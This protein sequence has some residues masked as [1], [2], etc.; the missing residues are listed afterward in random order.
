M[1]KIRPLV[2][3][4]A[5]CLV[6]FY[7]EPPYFRLLTLS[8]KKTNCYTLPTTPENVTALPCKMYNF[9]YLA[10]GMLYFS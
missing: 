4:I 10:E 3:D 6:G 5:Y 7:F 1:F 2:A 8:Q 9:F